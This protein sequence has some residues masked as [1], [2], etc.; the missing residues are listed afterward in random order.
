[1]PETSVQHGRGFDD[2]L[3]IL[4]D[5]IALA[6]QWGRPSLLLAVHKSKFGQEKADKELERRLDEAGFQVA[7]IAISDRRSIRAVDAQAPGARPVFFI[8]NIDWGGGEEGRQAYRALNL[9]RELF[10]EEAIK[11]VFWLTINEAANLP[12]YRFLGVPPVWLNS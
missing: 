11:A 7:R 2:N 4:F 3:D 10:V 1:M 5:E 6:A 9:H 12:R 8:S